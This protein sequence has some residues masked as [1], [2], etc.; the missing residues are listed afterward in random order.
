MQVRCPV[1]GYEATLTPTGPSTNRIIYPDEKDPKCPYPETIDEK[2]GNM[3]VRQMKCPNMEK[4]KEQA[5]S[6]FR[7]RSRK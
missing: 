2:T 6:A 3:N 7:S 4:A 5:V 1:C